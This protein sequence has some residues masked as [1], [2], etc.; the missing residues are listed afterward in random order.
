[1]IL[2]LPTLRADDWIAMLQG[3]GVPDLAQEFLWFQ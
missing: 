1:M 2:R 3:G